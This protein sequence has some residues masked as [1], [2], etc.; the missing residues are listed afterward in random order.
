MKTII[1]GFAAL[2]MGTGTVSALEGPGR[3]LL[4]SNAPLQISNDPVTTSQLGGGL[5]KAFIPPYSG[6][7]RVK[8][9]IRSHNG[10]AVPS[11]AYVQN[12]SQCGHQ[13]MTMAFVQRVCT[14]RVTGG[15]PIVIN[16]M[17]TDLNNQVSMRNVRLYYQV[18][19]S[20]GA[21]IV[22]ELPQQ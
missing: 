5:Q 7:V 17:V 16:A 13:I 10:S 8:W 18:V 1:V 3:A 12:L 6:T 9:E 22:Y 20:D 14:I 11:E 2:L 19:D 4:A 15:M 21:S